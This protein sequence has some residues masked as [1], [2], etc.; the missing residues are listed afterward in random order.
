MAL[1]WSSP[2]TMHQAHTSGIGS[3]L[4]DI[5]SSVPYR[6]Q[7]SRAYATPRWSVAQTCDVHNQPLWIGSARVCARAARADLRAR[8]VRRRPSPRPRVA[9]RRAE[10]RSPAR[11]LRP[12]GLQLSLAASQ[13]GPPRCAPKYCAWAS[14]RIVT[15]LCLRSSAEIRTASAA[16][17]RDPRGV[18]AHAT[19]SLRNT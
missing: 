4:C 2:S 8:A 14:S 15:R 13:R 12:L 7:K 5:C 3:R 9:R 18:R 11:R 16:S 6:S 1:P 10:A 19:A 17:A